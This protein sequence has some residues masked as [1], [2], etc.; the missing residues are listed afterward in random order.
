MEQEQRILQ[1]VHLAQYLA[2]TGYLLISECWV[3]QFFIL[4]NDIGRE[5]FPHTVSTQ[6][7]GQCAMRIVTWF[8][9]TSLH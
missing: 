3:F 1:R 2:L 8:Y 5:F 9:I 4:S 6:Q 7:K